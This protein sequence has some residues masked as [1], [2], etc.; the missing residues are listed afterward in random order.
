MHISSL[1]S[2]GQATIPAEI[3]EVLHLKAGDKVAFEVKDHLVII[4][5]LEP[6]DY[7]YHQA[8]SCT[9]HEWDSSEDEAYNDL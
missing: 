5:K 6:F 8:L 2:K 1:T 7:Q 3:R 9:L 4:S